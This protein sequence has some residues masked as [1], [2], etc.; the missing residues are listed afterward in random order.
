MR[1]QVFSS[2]NT[3]KRINSNL[4][5]N[6]NKTDYTTQTPKKQLIN[7]ALYKIYTVGHERDANKYPLTH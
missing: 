4:S 5:D 6:S 3:I 1:R 7:S 2:I